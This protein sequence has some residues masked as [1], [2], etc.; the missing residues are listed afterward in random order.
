MLF[1]GFEPGSV[2]CKD[3]CL[4]T[5]LPLLSVYISLSVYFVLAVEPDPLVSLVWFGLAR[6]GSSQY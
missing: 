4:T 5:R 2:K 6:F 1:L 3:T